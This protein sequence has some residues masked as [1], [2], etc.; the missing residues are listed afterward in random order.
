M[1]RGVICSHPGAI[2][3]GQNRRKGTAPPAADASPRRSVAKLNCRHFRNTPSALLLTTYFKQQKGVI[4]AA[5]QDVYRGRLA[6]SDIL[7]SLQPAAAAPLM[8]TPDGKFVGQHSN[9]SISSLAA[10]RLA[11]GGWH[12]G[13]GYRHGYYGNGAALGGLAAGAIIGGAIAN[14]QARAANADSYCSQRFKSYDPA[15]GR[16]LG[17]METGIPARNK[18]LMTCAGH[19]LRPCAGHGMGDSNPAPQHRGRTK[20]IA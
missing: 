5:F 19:C 3:G 2:W 13:Y 4:N 10:A 7:V 12:R 15:P 20:D 1:N 8:A 6:G 14:S 17:T 18:P 11:S 9:R 16:I